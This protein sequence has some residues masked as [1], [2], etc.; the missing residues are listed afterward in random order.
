MVAGQ[1][2]TYSKTSCTVYKPR[3]HFHQILAQFNLHQEAPP[4]LIIDELAPYLVEGTRKYSKKDV[5]T[6]MDNLKVVEG[7]EWVTKKE[8]YSGKRYEDM[9]Y[10]KYELR[11]FKKKWI[12]ILKLCVNQEPPK[13]S[14]EIETWL[15]R[16]FPFIEAV[17]VLVK[18][19]RIIFPRMRHLIRYLLMK[20]GWW[21]EEY[22]PY[23]PSVQ[24][25]QNKKD[26]EVLMHAMIEKAGT[27]SSNGR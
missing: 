2:S 5:W 18:G 6:V 1:N 8:P 15:K 11:L 19:S 23:F 24:G 12:H 25:G 14:I 9:E 16:V 13:M 21:V 26:Y 17:Y 22:E 4:Q 3:Y 10:R 27:F 20:K 7:Y